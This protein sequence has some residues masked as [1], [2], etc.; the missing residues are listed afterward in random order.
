ME[1]LRIVDP[2]SGVRS[3]HS[4]PFT[5]GSSSGRTFGF[6]PNDARSTRALAPNRR[7]HETDWLINKAGGLIY[8]LPSPYRPSY[9]CKV[10]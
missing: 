3:S 4:P 7:Q 8:L 10:V 6:D 5:A 2:V 1:K 9:N